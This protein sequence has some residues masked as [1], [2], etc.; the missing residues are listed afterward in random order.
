MVNGAAAD[1]TALAPWSGTPAGQRVLLTQLRGRLTQQQQVLAVY[2]ARDAR[3]A[4]VLRSMAYRSRLGGA[5]MPLSPSSLGADPGGSGLGS[6]SGLS[7]MPGLS[8]LANDAGN[9]NHGRIVLSGRHG[10][11]SSLPPLG[12]LSP[13]SGPREV[14][15]AII[16]EAQRRGYSPAQAIAIL[17]TGMQES[18]L[19]PRAVSPNGLWKDIFQQ[20]S[21][22]PGRDNPNTAISEFFNR[23][24]TKG[25][26]GVAG[27]LEIDLLAATG[28]GA[29]S[30]DQA[31]AQG[32]RGCSKPVASSSLPRTVTKA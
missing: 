16:R 9:R 30:A 20:D 11:E 19:N 17:S 18:G 13:S 22:Y 2:K 24:E 29:A 5:G 27:Y 28:A 7:G 26:P 23:L 3:L 15:A 14:A 12:A 25:G 21:S 1:T 10:I 8:G 32:R 31:Y 4:A 6:I